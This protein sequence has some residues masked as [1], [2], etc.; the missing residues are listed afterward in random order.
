MNY[1]GL[2]QISCNVISTKKGARLRGSESDP[3]LDMCAELAVNGHKCSSLPK[4][5]VSEYKDHCS[6]MTQKQNQ[7]VSSL[8]QTSP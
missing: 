7:I 5:E 4:I 3:C 1:T 8:C 6:P 2:F